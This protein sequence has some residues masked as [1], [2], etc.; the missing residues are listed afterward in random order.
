MWRTSRTGRPRTCLPAGSARTS[1]TTTARRTS[2]TRTVPDGDYSPREGGVHVLATVDETTYD[3]QD[4]NDH[5]RRSSDLV[6]PALRRR[7]LVVHGHGPHG[8]VVLRARLP[9]AYPGGHRDHGGRAA[10]PSARTRA[11][12]SRPRRPADRHAPLAVQFT[13]SGSDPENQALI[14]SWDFGDGGSA[15]GQYATHTYLR[16]APTWRR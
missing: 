1:G 7:P 8:R 10:R 5:R 15:F 11:R 13:S 4:G 9:R 6:V 14:Y 16:P 2:P 12:A 3:E